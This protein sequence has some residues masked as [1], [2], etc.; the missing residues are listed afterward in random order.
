MSDL[1]AALGLVFVIEGICLAAFPLSAKR[2]IATILAMPEAPLRA[3]GI[4]SAVV[5]LVIVWLIRR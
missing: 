5:G 2:A 4:V 3:T 1:L